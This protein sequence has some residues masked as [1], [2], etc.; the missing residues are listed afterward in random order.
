MM[1]ETNCIFHLHVPG[2]PKMFMH[3]VKTR[4]KQF[5]ILKNGGK[6]EEKKKR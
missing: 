5:E 1:V 4:A 3:M 6:V 2:S